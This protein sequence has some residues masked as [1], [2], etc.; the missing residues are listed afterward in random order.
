[1]SLPHPIRIALIDDHVLVRDGVKSL[2]SAM[3]HFADFARE[4]RHF[5]FVGCMMAF[6]FYFLVEASCRDGSEKS[7]GLWPVFLVA[8]LLGHAIGYLALPVVLV[9]LLLAWRRH[10]LSMRYVPA[11]AIAILLYAAIQAKYGDG[12]PGCRHSPCTCGLAAKP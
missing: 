10:L 1:M 4:A 7:R 12:C 8:T 9:V 11:Y 3:P 5:T 6:T 2:L